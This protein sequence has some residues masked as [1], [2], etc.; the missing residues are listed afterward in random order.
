MGTE[1]IRVGMNMPD[2]HVNRTCENMDI[3]QEDFDFFIIA[4]CRFP[5]EIEYVKQYFGEDSVYTVRVHRMNFESRLTEEQRQHPSETSL[6]DWEDW[7]YKIIAMG[8]DL[9]ALHKQCE[10][11]ADKIL[12]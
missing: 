3:L 11:I 1:K 4:D 5:N 8:S 10:M 7:D 6:D 9:N 2:F 12:V